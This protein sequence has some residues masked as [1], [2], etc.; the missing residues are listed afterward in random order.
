MTARLRSVP[1]PE[2]NKPPRADLHDYEGQQRA[3]SAAVDWAA[4]HIAGDRREP[5]AWASTK[6]RGWR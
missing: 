5:F 1:A 2:P 4:V 3:A 6:R